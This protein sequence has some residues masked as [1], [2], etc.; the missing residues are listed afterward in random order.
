MQAAQCATFSEGVPVTV[1]A[2]QAIAHCALCIVSRAQVYGRA[3]ER[4]PTIIR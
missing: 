2:P 1:A 3:T 4:L